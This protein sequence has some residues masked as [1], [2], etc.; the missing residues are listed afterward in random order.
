MSSFFV[1]ITALISNVYNR[2]FLMLLTHEKIMLEGET[3][4]AF[5]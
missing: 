5:M 3:C 1:Q 4:E 2:H